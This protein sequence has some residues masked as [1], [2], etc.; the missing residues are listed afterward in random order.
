MQNQDTDYDNASAL[1][2]VLTN[3]K[4]NMSLVEIVIVVGLTSTPQPPR[5]SPSPFDDKEAR[6]ALTWSGLR[7]WVA[8]PDGEQLIFRG[9]QR[10]ASD[11]LAE[12]E[13]PCQSCV[14]SSNDS[15]D[16]NSED[17][18]GYDYMEGHIQ[19][20]NVS[21][22]EEIDDDALKQEKIR[23]TNQTEA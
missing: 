9:D 15:D 7:R 3:S 19:D 10:F 5:W 13:P 12:N 16:H 8:K 22:M 17:S 20:E 1:F 11:L 2:D 14:S 18:S 21:E 6:S 23:D 4:F